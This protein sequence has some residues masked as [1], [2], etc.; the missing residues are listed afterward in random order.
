M[1]T[2]VPLW[3][4]ITGISP[5]ARKLAVSPDMAIRFGSARMVAWFWVAS[6]SMSMSRPRTAA[7]PSSCASSGPRARSRCWSRVRTPDGEINVEIIDASLAEE[8]E[9][10]Y[11]TDLTT[12]LTLPDPGSDPVLDPSVDPMAGEYGGG[13]TTFQCLWMGV[14]VIT[15]AGDTPVSRASASVLQ[16]V[17][18][19]D[20]VG[21]ARSVGALHLLDRRLAAH[22]HRAAA[23]HQRRPCGGPAR[24]S[25]RPHP[26]P[27]RGARRG[28]GRSERRRAAARP[29]G[30][31]PVHRCRRSASARPLHRSSVRC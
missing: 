24:G 9:R 18:L 25:S 6:R 17:G 12:L 3:G 15:F 4:T 30:R 14:P 11:R 23:R 19:G 28:D 20:L 2:P 16:A 10:I 8:M 27:R 31:R 1:A 21:A 5:P 7:T 26:A 13:T 29:P 22:D